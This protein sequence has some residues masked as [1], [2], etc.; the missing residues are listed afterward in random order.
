MIDAVIDDKYKIVAELGK[1]GAGIVY[2][3]E[4]KAL[5]RSVAIKVLHRKSKSDQALIREARN[6]LRVQHPNIVKVMAVGLADDGR[7]FLVMEYVDGVPLDTFIAENGTLTEE[8]TVSIAIQVASALDVAHKQKVIHRDLKSANIMI[9][10]TADKPVAKILD[11]GLAKSLDPQ[12]T[13]SGTATSTGGL[14]GS[15]GYMSPEVCSGL[16]ADFQSDIYSLGCVL[17]E[18][19]SG[20]VPFVADSWIG[21][22]QMHKEAI[23]KSL[24]SSYHISPQLEMLISKCLAKSAG[25][26]FNS[27]AEICRA[28][29]LIEKG[30]GL[31][32]LELETLLLQGTP[33]HKRIAKTQGAIIASALVLISVLAMIVTLKSNETAHLPKIAVPDN[34]KQGTKSESKKLLHTSVALRIKDLPYLYEKTIEHREL[35][36]ELLRKIDDLLV[37]TKRPDQFYVLNQIKA[38]IYWDQHQFDNA[39]TAFQKAVHFARLTNNNKESIRSMHSLIGLTDSYK[40]LGQT[41]QYRKHL[42]ELC[43]LADRAANGNLPDL[44]LPILESQYSSLE[45]WN[46]VSYYI[47]MNAASSEKDSDDYEAAI[48]HATKAQQAT[49]K[50]TNAPELLIADCQFRAG[51]KKDGTATLEKAKQKLNQLKVN[52][53]SGAANLIDR[54]EDRMGVASAMSNMGDWF[55]EHGDKAKALEYFQE[56]VKMADNSDYYAKQPVIIQTK[57][58]IRFLKSGKELA[59]SPFQL[60]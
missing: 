42:T 44:K 6:L 9:M 58:K 26:R 47:Y 5:K 13:N 31:E 22:L 10:T 1:G 3:A 49:A 20:Q 37:L 59:K 24:Q 17:Y 35:S 18:C 36:T 19:I 60:P 7:P 54:M 45:L 38:K 4:Q 28:L 46:P 32:D 23:P 14:V 57:E 39:I 53:E 51:R 11:F 16:K 12:L 56:A 27:A 25:A 48:E 40:N 30:S 52:E 29:E 33:S 50:Y 41:E 34:A 2:R 43:A 55:Y 21:L 15:V 8:Q